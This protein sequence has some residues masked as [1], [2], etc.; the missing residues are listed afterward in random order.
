[1]PAI[2]NSLCKHCLIKWVTDCPS[3]QILAEDAL[4]KRVLIVDCCLFGD[5]LTWGANDKLTLVAIFYGCFPG[6]VKVL[7]SVCVHKKIPVKRF[8]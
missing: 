2:R 6:V 8:D 4:F 1:V 7:D 5:N 3:G